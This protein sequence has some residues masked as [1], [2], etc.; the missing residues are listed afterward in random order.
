MSCFF[1][2]IYFAIVNKLYLG[3]WGVAGALVL[4]LTGEPSPSRRAAGLAVFI[5]LNGTFHLLALA[6]LADVL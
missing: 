6:S 5:I 2:S 1:I 3:S 4:L